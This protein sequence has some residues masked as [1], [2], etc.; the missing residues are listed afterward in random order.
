MSDE[1]GAR[2]ITQGV[3]EMS[4]QT[5][6]QPVIAEE[7]QQQG[8]V[9]SVALDQEFELN[10]FNHPSFSKFNG[11][12]VNFMT[13]P[14]DDHVDFIGIL[15]LPAMSSF[16]LLSYLARNEQRLKAIGVSFFRDYLVQSASALGINESLCQDDYGFSMT[17]G[18]VTDEAIALFNPTGR[19]EGP[20]WLLN[21]PTYLHYTKS[22]LLSSQDSRFDVW[23]LVINAYVHLHEPHRRAKPVRKWFEDRQRMEAERRANDAERM[24][25]RAAKLQQQQQQQQQDETLV[26][27]PRQQY[28]SQPTYPTKGQLYP[29]AGLS[30]LPSSDP[31]TPRYQ[32][33]RDPQQNLSSVQMR[34]N[35]RPARGGK[36]PSGI[37]TQNQVSFNPAIVTQIVDERINQIEQQ[38]WPTMPTVQPI[39][40]ADW[41]TNGIPGLPPV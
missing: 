19:H 24:E 14:T 40:H 31:H 4:V 23:H 33:F 41:H 1:V 7:E 17:V 2:D 16:K 13:L 22:N 18:S 3:T 37:R 6:D 11:T 15:R 36:V 8:V 27:Q 28:Y 34:Q 21:V 9:V 26:V 29:P 10:R 39:T 38:R 35:A 32:D 20:L 30:Y 12:F 5:M 25:R